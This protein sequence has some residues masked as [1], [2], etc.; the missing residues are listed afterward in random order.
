[1][2]VFYYK[3][4]SNGFQVMNEW[5]QWKE[6]ELKYK[7]PTPHTKKNVLPKKLAGKFEDIQGEI[8]K[9]NSLTLFRY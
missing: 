2:L 1:M 9:E 7:A 6:T 5:N 4:E 3:I 8:Q